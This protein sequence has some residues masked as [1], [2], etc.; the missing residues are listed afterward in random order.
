MIEGVEI[1]PLRIIATE[2]GDVFHGMKKSDLGYCGFG[3]AYFSM[4]DFGAIKGWKR[5]HKMVLNLIVPVGIV[6]FVLYDD[7]LD[8]V[9][10]GKFQEITLSKE[11]NYCRLT[12]PHLLW[13]GFQGVGKNSNILLN[14]ANIEHGAKEVDRKDLNEIRYDW[15]LI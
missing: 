4:I 2:G 1:T 11:D 8:S 10:C 14:V 13:M 7:R 15:E 3:E 9:S 5:H 6:R 12:V